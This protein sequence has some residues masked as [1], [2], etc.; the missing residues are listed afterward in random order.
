MLWAVLS[1]DCRSVF[2]ILPISAQFSLVEY[3]NV[4]T[5]FGVS[6]FILM[7]AKTM[8]SVGMRKGSH[9]G[10]G[11]NVRPLH[12]F[13]VAGFLAFA[14]TISSILRAVFDE[15]RYGAIGSAALSAMCVLFTAI[16]FYVLHATEQLL[17]K[18]KSGSLKS[19]K[20][21]DRNRRAQQK[22]RRLKL[23]V[24]VLGTLVSLW[25]VWITYQSVTKDGL[26][27]DATTEPDKYPAMQVVGRVIHWAI[28]W[29][30]LYAVWIKKDQLQDKSRPDKSSETSNSNRSYRSNLALSSARPSARRP[31]PSSTPSTSRRN[32]PP[33]PIRTNTAATSPT[34]PM[35]SWP[36]TPAMSPRNGELINTA[37]GIREEEEDEAEEETLQNSDEENLQNSVEMEL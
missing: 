31:F 26:T 9:G 11:H 6:F 30:L 29:T 37:V 21:T 19:S 2:D 14:V 4:T 23:I 16:G 20:S 24:I 18:H 5:L 34:S 27:T 28:V 7:F 13:L 35:S 15:E 36:S 12:I 17:I 3:A 10:R 8:V 1:I 25:N 33:N 22:T 32:F